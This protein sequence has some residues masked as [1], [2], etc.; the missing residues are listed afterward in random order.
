MS[1]AEL[2]EQIK[3]LSHEEQ[4]AVREFL[5]HGESGLQQPG[6]INYIHEEH[7]RAVADRVFEGHRDL[8]RKLAE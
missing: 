3:A 2:I 5:L 8:F 6:G 1:V 7:F 4:A